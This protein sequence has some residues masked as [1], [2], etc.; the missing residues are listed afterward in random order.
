VGR[1]LHPVEV[2][3]PLCQ[4]Q[5]D[6]AYHRGVFGF[7]AG[8]D[9][10]DGQHPASQCAPTW[11]DFALDKVG[12]SAKGPDDALDLGLGGRNDRQAVGPTSLEV[13]FD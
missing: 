3:L 10:V 4:T 6:G 8:H 9:H 13:K 7:T 1:G 5:H 12:I 11:S 2:E